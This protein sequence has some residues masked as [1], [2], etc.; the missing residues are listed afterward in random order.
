MYPLKRKAV[1][2]PTPAASLSLT[3]AGSATLTWAEGYTSQTQLPQRNFE[4]RSSLVPVQQP[5]VPTSDVPSIAPP[6][7]SLPTVPISGMEL[8]HPSLQGSPKPLAAVTA[9]SSIHPSF[10]STLPS[11]SVIPSSRPTASN[12][13]SFGTSRCKQGAGSMRGV[14]HTRWQSSM[15]LPFD[16][17]P[18]ETGVN[19]TSDSE[20]SED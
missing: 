18:R 10:R 8:T 16:V 12:S 3:T 20:D 17:T 7:I 15:D 13:I 6:Q 14:I 5:M 9:A 11:V 1:A 4:S 19:D 2:P